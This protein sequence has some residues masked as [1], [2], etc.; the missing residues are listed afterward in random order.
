MVINIKINVKKRRVN[1]NNIK[2]WYNKYIIIIIVLTCIKC[3]F[4]ICMYKIN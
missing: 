1:I 2:K 3:Y 4:K